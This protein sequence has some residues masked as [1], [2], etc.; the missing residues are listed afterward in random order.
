MTPQKNINA[1]TKTT[2]Q[3]LQDIS[4]KRHGERHNYNSAAKGLIH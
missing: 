3:M 4:I 2:H 1:V